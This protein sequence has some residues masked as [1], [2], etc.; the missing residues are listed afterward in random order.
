IFLRILAYGKPYGKV[1]PIYALTTLLHSIFSVFNI[2]MLIPLFQVLFNEEPINITQEP[3]F[4]ISFSYLSN[5]FY[6]HFGS[7]IAE[8]GKL[9][10]LYFVTGLIVTS[11]LLSNIFSIITNYLTAKIRVRVISKFRK[12][13]FSKVSKFDLSYFTLKKKGD[14]VARITTDLQQVEGTVV[15]VLKALIKEPLMIIGYFIVLFK[16]S[17][18]LTLY[19][20]AII[21]L[22]G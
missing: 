3:D 6:Y 15:G 13:A 16:I 21:P 9:S 14:T 8:F 12:Q 11:F 22:S 5:L 10:A 2:S 17:V 7:I 19:T 20:L 1:V 18:P 4:T